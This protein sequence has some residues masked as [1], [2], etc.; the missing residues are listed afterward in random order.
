MSYETFD[1]S[2]SATGLAL[3]AVAASVA[4]VA[5]SLTTALALVGVVG[6]AAATAGVYLQ[7]RRLVTVGTVVLFG[8]V[9]LAGTT[10]GP[11]ALVVLGAGATVVAWD[12]GT[13]AISVGR[14]LGAAAAT[15]RIEVAHTLAS[16]AYAVLVGGVVYAAYGLARGGQPTLAVALSLVA[17]VLFAVLLDE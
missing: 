4:L 2:A 10:G 15:S 13:N 17:A 3:T 7:S 8:V 6:V 11:L 12:A 16:S 9:L 1:E 14:Q 5:A